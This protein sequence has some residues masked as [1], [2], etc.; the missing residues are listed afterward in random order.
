MRFVVSPH[1]ALVDVLRVSGVRGGQGPGLDG[2]D[3]GAGQTP[4][5]ETL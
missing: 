2:G 3:G 4:G 1:G 5:G